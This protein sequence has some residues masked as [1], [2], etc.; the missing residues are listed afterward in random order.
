MRRRDGAIR[1]RFI[2]GYV[3]PDAEYRPLAPI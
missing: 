3:D 1:S 2:I